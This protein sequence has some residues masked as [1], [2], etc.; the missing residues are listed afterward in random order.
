MAIEKVA[1]AVVVRPWSTRAAETLLSPDSIAACALLS[2]IG[3][4][5]AGVYLLAGT[6][7]AL[8][9]GAV[10]LLL[11]GGVLLRGILRGW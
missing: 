6:A 10:P 2:G 3:L 5:V 7:W 1:E 4:T 8:I 9:A 11:L